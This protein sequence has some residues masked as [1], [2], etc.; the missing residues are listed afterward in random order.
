MSLPNNV[1]WTNGDVITETKLDGMTDNDEHL[2]DGTAIDG[3]VIVSR[4]LKPIE[5]L[6]AGNSGTILNAN[7]DYD[8]ATLTVTLPAYATGYNVWIK[9][10][11]YAQL[12]TAGT[13]TLNVWNDGVKD[14][15]ANEQGVAANSVSALM[16]IGICQ[17]WKVTAAAG[18]RTYKVSARCNI[19]NISN[20]YGSLEVRASSQ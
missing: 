1:V 12:N 20:V 3:A 10:S 7:A 16:K 15:N 17:R 5:D 14:T 8:I 11:G 2:A 13:V 9:F 6:I 19:G 4:H 18:A